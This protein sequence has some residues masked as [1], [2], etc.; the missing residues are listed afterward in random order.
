MRHPTEMLFPDQFKTGGDKWC[1]VLFQG[2]NITL[3]F[4][5][6]AQPIPQVASEE[7]K[8]IIHIDDHANAPRR[9]QTKDVSGAIEFFTSSV[10]VTDRVHPENEIKCSFQPGL[11]DLKRSCEI[12]RQ[13]LISRDV[14]SN[15]PKLI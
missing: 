11:V 7:G 15:P 6:P 14:E 2:R 1:S 12:A 4:L 13:G 5:L 9:Q 8:T 10:T 3:L